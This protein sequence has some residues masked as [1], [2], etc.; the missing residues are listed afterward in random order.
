MTVRHHRRPYDHLRCCSGRHVWLDDTARERC[1]DPAWRK[2]LIAAYEWDTR[3]E[4]R[5][6]RRALGGRRPR[7]RMATQRRRRVIA[8]TPTIL[9][10]GV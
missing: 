5:R 3:A 2:V 6:V 4:R 8:V 1:C 10:R 7:L 9:L